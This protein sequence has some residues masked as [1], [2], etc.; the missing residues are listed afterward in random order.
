MAVQVQN[1][2][3]QFHQLI[4]L[5]HIN[6]SFEKGQIHGFIGP[7]GAGKTTAMRIMATLDL[8]DDGDVSI[9]G[10]SVLEKPQEVRK[11]IGFVPDWFH[12]Y[13]NITVHEYLDFFARSHDLKGKLRTTTVQEIEEFTNLTPL[14]DKLINGLS[15]GMQQRVSLGRSLIN[16]PDI[17][18]MD[19]PAANLD[20]RA[21]ID[22]RELVKALANR[23]KA[24][25]ISSHILPELAE[26][27]DSITVIDHGR[28]LK[29]GS[30]SDIN[31]ELKQGLH[32][33]QIRTLNPDEMTEKFLYEQPGIL[34][35]RLNGKY[36]QFAF[37]GEEEDMAVLLKQ[38]VNAGIDIIEFK[39]VEEGLED[40]FM[41]ITQGHQ[42][43]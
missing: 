42:S 8:P 3:K 20:P 33:I 19:E 27:C 30:L 41:N 7:N 32:Q 28:I 31:K 23:N 17:L 21:R 5:N 16:N 38:M 12:G 9:D 37:T 15:R 13:N 35:I 18:I 25:L 36:V 34:D 14:K 39:S 10:I 11:K 29:S 4:A 2:Y 22:F 26:I 6:F 1:L 40:V 43:S 24:I